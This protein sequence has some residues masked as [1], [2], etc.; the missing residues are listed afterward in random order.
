MDFSVKFCGLN[1]YA[2][3]KEYKRIGLKT[4]D[5]IREELGCNLPIERIE[6]KIDSHNLDINV[7]LTEEQ[8]RK[9]GLF[10][11]TNTI[12]VKTPR[13]FF[14]DCVVEVIKPKIDINTNEIK[15]AYVYYQTDK[16]AIFSKWESLGFKED[17]SI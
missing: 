8:A 14:N 1:G 10:K 3:E 5:K 17:L 2:V 16:E 4:V 15:E 12:T 9:V 7:Y 13:G 6:E 11:D